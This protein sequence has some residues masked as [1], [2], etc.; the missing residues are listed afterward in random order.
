MPTITDLLRSAWTFYRKHSALNDIVLW[1]IIVPTFAI[2]TLSRLGSLDSD[3]YWAGY[4]APDTVRALCTVLV[5]VL[6][7]VIAWGTIAVILVGRQIVKPADHGGSWRQILR[8]GS[9]LLVPV[10]LTDVLRG[11]F[12]FLWL[13]LLVVPGI[14]YLFRTAFAQIIIVCE[15]LQYRSALRRSQDLVRGRTGTVAWT[16]VLLSLVVFVPVGF[17]VGF[18][19]AA[20]AALDPRLLMISDALQSAVTG[21]AGAIVLLAMIELYAFLVKT[22]A[23]K[24][25]A[26]RTGK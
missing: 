1:T 6:N 22:P 16:I 24:K 25:V 12:I 5:V 13:L 17:V 8:R 4:S 21:I 2:A 26:K 7:V 9:P 10:I 23:I 11:C 20:I 3:P 15:G 14:I 18:I 19:E